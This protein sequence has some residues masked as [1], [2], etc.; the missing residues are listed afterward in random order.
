MIVNAM[1][2]AQLYL[3][4]IYWRKSENLL[5]FT[6]GP[7]FLEGKSINPW[8]TGLRRVYTLIMPIKAPWQNWK[9]SLK[10]K[11]GLTFLTEALVTCNPP[12]HLVTPLFHIL[13]LCTSYK[14]LNVGSHM[15]FSRYQQMKL[16]S[17]WPK[18][19]LKQAGVISSPHIEQQC[20]VSFVL[21]SVVL[22]LN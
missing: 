22:T 18:V 13:L 7:A 19:N 8:V 3:Q 21:Q 4:K 15:W 9:F 14:L 11:G 12:P 6:E 10:W 17:L 5:V 2:L 16:R 1:H 20:F